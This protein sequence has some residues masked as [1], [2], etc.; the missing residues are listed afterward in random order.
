M[1][2]IKIKTLKKII[3]TGG[4]AGYAPLM[5]GT[6]GTLMAMLIVIAEFLFF[7]SSSWIINFIMVL[8]CFYPAIK[9]GDEGEQIFQRKDPP[10]VVLDEIIGYWISLLFFS[11]SWPL[12]LA[13]FF[14][15]R[16][17]DILKPFP[18]NR[19]EKIPGGLGIM[20]DDYLAGF[21][22][23]IILLILKILG[24]LP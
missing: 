11:F 13:A 9:L 19:L 15:F 12:I 18:I 6:F 21:Y 20:L 24:F 10:E 4:Y 8:V 1:E 17:M 22:T 2:K 23:W 7:G 5:P 3:L 16:L 14:I